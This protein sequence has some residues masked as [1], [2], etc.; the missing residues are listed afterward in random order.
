MRHRFITT[1]TAVILAIALAIGAKPAAAQVSREDVGRIAAGVLGAVVLGQVLRD[2]RRDDDAARRPGSIRVETGGRHDNRPAFVDGR[3]DRGRH[4]G[5]DRGRGRGRG[6]DYGRDWGH[7]RWERRLS[8][9]AEC[10]QVADT[11]SGRRAVLGPRCMSDYGV[12]VSRLPGRC[13]TTLASYRREIP[14]WGA[15]C[16]EDHGYR[17][18][19]GTRDDRRG[20]W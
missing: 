14:V 10:V 16:L 20:R 8:L 1:G 19:F 17:I 7:D 2:A 11:R 5:H 6:G 12:A 4:L 3:R 9:P 18:S 15:R 13:A